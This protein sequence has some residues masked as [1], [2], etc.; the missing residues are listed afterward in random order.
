MI[1]SYH[2]LLLDTLFN[3]Q[4]QVQRLSQGGGGQINVNIDSYAEDTR[5]RPSTSQSGL[6][7]FNPGST[8]GVVGQVRKA[9]SALDK[10]R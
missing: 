7:Q 2:V 8:R 1:C 9:A 6:Y 5:L 3:L 10:F 4:G